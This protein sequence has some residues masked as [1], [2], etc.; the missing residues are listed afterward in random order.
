[1]KKRTN[2][3]ATAL[4]LGTLL[5][6]S[7]MPTYTL[8]EAE[9]ETAALAETLTEYPASTADEAGIFEPESAISLD[10]L[11]ENRGTFSPA[12]TSSLLA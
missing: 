7:A 3:S 12:T 9:I 5:V 2:L 10:E 11:S 6:S 8:A 1:M 4:T